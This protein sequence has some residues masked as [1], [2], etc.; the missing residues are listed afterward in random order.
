MSFKLLNQP[1]PFT[2]SQRKKVIQA[3]L[4]GLFVFLFLLIFQPFGL[5]NYQNDY[6]VLQILGY[7]AVTTLSMLASNFSFSLFFPKWYDLRSWTVGKNILYILWMFFLIGMNN[8]IYSIMLGFWGFSIR[9]FLIFQAVTLLIG[10]FPVTISTLIIYHNRLKAALKEAQALNQNIH[11]HHPA[12]NKP[13]ILIPSQNK[14]ENLNVDLEHLLY[15]KAVENYVELCLDNKKVILRN[16]LKSVEMTLAD[17]PQFKRCH[18][19][20][21]VNLHKVKSFSGNAQGLSLKFEAANVEEIPV[22]RAYV[23]EIKAA[24]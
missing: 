3:F 1:Y 17:F 15:V 22:S 8:W 19:S 10:I 5:L 6:K 21:L 14:S 4:F 13:V 12:I 20:F 18:R 2:T 11:P 24:L 23:P 16:T 9:A 7:G